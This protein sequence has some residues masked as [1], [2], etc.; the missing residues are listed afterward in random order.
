[1]RKVIAKSMHS[2]PRNLNN[3]TNLCDDTVTILQC[4]SLYISHTHK[5]PPKILFKL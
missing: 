1:M 3:M 2:V 4:C 5:P